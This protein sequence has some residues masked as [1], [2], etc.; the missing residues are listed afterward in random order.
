M[1]AVLRHPYS[2]S[3]IPIE[4]L[5]SRSDLEEDLAQATPTQMDSK[6]EL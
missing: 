1:F 2:V 4:D 6:E 3:T 5:E